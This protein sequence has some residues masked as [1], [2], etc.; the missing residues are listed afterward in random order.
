MFIKWTHA[1]QCH[2][3]RFLSD[4]FWRNSSQP[5]LL[6]AIEAARFWI[7]NT[8]IKALPHPP[9][10]PRCLLSFHL[11]PWS[12]KPQEWERKLSC[13]FHG[14]RRAF[15]SLPI[16]AE[17]LEM[18]K[19]HASHPCNFKY[20]SIMKSSDCPAALRVKNCRNKQHRNGILLNNCGENRRSSR[21]SSN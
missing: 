11:S 9:T 21:F 5:C 8:F 18:K 2:L 20:D 3:L 17:F 6:Q 1:L 12:S 16:R 13:N 15:F 4:N 14:K 7:Q 19:N 10:H